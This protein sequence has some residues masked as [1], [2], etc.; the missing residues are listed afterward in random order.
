MLWFV[1][2]LLN[3]V[4]VRHTQITPVYY[5]VCKVVTS[6]RVNRERVV[7]SIQGVY[8][9]RRIDRTIHIGARSDCVV[10]Y[11]EVGRYAVFRRYTAECVGV[12]H[13][14]I[15]PVYYHVCYMIPG[16]PRNREHVIA[17]IQSVDR[18]RW[19]D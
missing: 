19:I 17:S 9:A 2:T 16:E 8:R 11:P 18:T 4:G 15:T 5:H 12:R 10:I 7:T 14:Q 1:A 13:T 3:A 6:I